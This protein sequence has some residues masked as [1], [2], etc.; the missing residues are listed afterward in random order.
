MIDV[1]DIFAHFDFWRNISNKRADFADFTFISV[2]MGQTLPDFMNEMEI[3]LSFVINWS[4][5]YKFY[6]FNHSIPVSS[7]IQELS[8]ISQSFIEKDPLAFARLTIH[9]STISSLMSKNRE[10]DDT[11]PRSISRQTKILSPRMISL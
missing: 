7:S 8:I 10:D 3:N 6:N 9:D 5:I 2:F 4:F 1:H 11:D